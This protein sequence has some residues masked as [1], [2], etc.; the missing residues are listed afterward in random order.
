[1]ILEA[2]LLRYMDVSSERFP[3]VQGFN[4]AL[5]RYLRIGSPRTPPSLASLGPDGRLQDIDCKA[6]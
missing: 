3:E 5:L 4:P 2:V 1:M 6:A